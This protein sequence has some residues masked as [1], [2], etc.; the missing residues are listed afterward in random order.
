MIKNLGVADDDQHDCG[1]KGGQK[2]CLVKHN[3]VLVSPEPLRMN[4]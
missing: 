2:L 3:G 1:T 4:S